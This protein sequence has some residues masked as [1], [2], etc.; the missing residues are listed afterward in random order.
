MARNIATQHMM[1]IKCVLCLQNGR[2]RIGSVLRLISNVHVYTTFVFLMS[3]NVC[4]HAAYDSNPN[5][6]MFH[7]LLSFSRLSFGKNVVYKFI[8]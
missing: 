6:Y 4:L 2:R 8:H 1:I 3:T 7:R 5:R